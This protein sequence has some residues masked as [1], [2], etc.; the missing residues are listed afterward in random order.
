VVGQPRLTTHPTGAQI[1]SN[2][3]VKLSVMWLNVRPVNSGVREQLLVNV[4]I[5][6]SLG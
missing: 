1:S 4:G 2:V 5:L 6:L 3:I